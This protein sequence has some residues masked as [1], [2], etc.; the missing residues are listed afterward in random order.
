MGNYTLYKNEQQARRVTCAAQR[1]LAMSLP[2]NAPAGTDEVVAMYGRTVRMVHLAPETLAGTVG[3]LSLYNVEYNLALHRRAMQQVAQPCEQ[4]GLAVE[5]LGEYPLFRGLKLVQGRDTDV[6]IVPADDDPLLTSGKFPMPRK[7]HGRMEALRKAG[8]PFERLYTYI[9]H[10]VPRGSVS[11]DGPLTLEA[12]TPPA[13]RSGVR[14][15]RCLGNVAHAMTH[16]VLAA[17]GLAARG[18]VYGAALAGAG[19]ETL[20]ILLDPLIFGAFAD[21]RGM[22]TWFVLAQWAW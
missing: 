17:L 9:A 3:V 21:E 13:P 6:V 14:T 20:S 11:P 10:E 5:A 7:V 2:A 12:I 4:L 18:G 8:V 19:A 15:S 16:T 22:A 1:A